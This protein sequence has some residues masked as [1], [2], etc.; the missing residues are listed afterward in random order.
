MPPNDTLSTGDSPKGKVT[1]GSQGSVSPIRPNI[2][3]SDK[4]G[5][6]PQSSYINAD[7]VHELNAMST[8][9]HQ[10]LDAKLSLIEERMDRRVAD[11]SNTVT[12]SVAEL[13]TTQ[14]SVDRTMMHFDKTTDELKQLYRE[15]VTRSKEDKREMQY[16]TVTIAVAVVALIFSMVADVKE[17]FNTFLSQETAWVQ[18]SLD[19]LEN[20]M[21]LVEQTNQK[22]ISS[23]EEI[24]QDI[25]Q[26]KDAVKKQ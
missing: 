9:S 12:Q 14:Q 6:M 4:L 7:T 21:G 5:K 1:A 8:I 24:K 10:E 15:S 3:M 19:A 13:K 26:R 17:S 18:R 16:F 2:D 25:R 20:R 22:I 23:L 11:L